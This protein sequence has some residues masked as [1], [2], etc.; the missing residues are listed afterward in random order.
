M[1]NYFT[2]RKEIFMKKLIVFSVV[3]LFSSLGFAQDVSILK[4][5]QVT[6]CGPIPGC[7]ASILDIDTQTNYI[8]DSNYAEDFLK[9]EA[10]YTG[11]TRT[12]NIK[13]ALG[14]IDEE[15]R[16]CPG[17][18]GKCLVFKALKFIK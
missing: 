11:Q 15:A 12:T 2:R 1:T 13:E 17:L 8:L 3:T 6:I 10:N 16:R 14:V 5:A 7:V 4:N 9:S 18:H